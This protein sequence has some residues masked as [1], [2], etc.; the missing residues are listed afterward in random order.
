[1]MAAE[2]L[3]QEYGI[4]AEV[5]D[6]RTVDAGYDREAIRQSILKTGHVLIA[7]EDRAMGGF[8]SS[9]ASEIA[10]EWWYDLGGPIGRVH[11]KFSRVSY[12]PAGEKA[13]MTSPDSVVAEALRILR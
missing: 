10:S 9:V 6:L 2:K 1:M 4:S 12:G 7:D 11:P 3:Q 5:I 13:V 8:G